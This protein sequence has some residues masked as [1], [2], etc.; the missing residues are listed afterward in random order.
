MRNRF[1]W[2]L[3]TIMMCGVVMTG[4]TSCSNVDNNDGNNKEQKRVAL[5]LPDASRINR[6]STDLANL[7]DAMA[8]YGIKTTSYVAPETAE[9]A[10]QQVEQLRA[11]F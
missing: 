2:M 4:L 9:G 8:T 6:W 1:F 11:A 5:L 7:E 3:V 10:M